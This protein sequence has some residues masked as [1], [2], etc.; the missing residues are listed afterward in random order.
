MKESKTLTK[1]ISC[2]GECKFDDIYQQWNNDKCWCECKNPKEHHVSGKIYIWNTA[3]CSYENGKNAESIIDD[4]VVTY[5]EI[6]EETNTVQA[7]SNSRK[8]ILTKCTSANQSF[9]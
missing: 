4:S 1:H 9:H 8:A 6:I 2:K 5:D 7:K 3:R